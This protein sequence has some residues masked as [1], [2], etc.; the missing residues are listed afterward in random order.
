MRIKYC[1]RKSQ[2]RFVSGLCNEQIESFEPSGV[3][4]MRISS[5]EGGRGKGANRE[6]DFAGIG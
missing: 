3:E 1:N 5:R 4:E 2:K 6:T